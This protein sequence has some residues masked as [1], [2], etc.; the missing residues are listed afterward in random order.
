MGKGGKT[1]TVRSPLGREWERD[2]ISFAAL[3]GK[4]DA[5]AHLKQEALETKEES[6]EQAK[7]V[8]IFS[9]LCYDIEGN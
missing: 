6:K 9:M 5:V 1:K 8:C 4:L 7:E 2:P 3:S